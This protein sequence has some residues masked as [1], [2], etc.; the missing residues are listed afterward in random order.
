M[1][2]YRD[3]KELEEGGVEI[4]FDTDLLFC[5]LNVNKIKPP[6]NDIDTGCNIVP[7]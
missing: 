4:T 5:V 3:S 7:Q 6:E 1:I 2:W